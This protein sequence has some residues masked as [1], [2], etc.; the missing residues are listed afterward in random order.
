VKFTYVRKTISGKKNGQ[1]R[2]DMAHVRRRGHPSKAQKTV[3]I[4]KFPSLRLAGLTQK[5]YNFLK[6]NATFQKAHRLRKKAY[7]R[8]IR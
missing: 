3:S 2:R 4:Y 6:I 1:A 5:F 7:P 8:Q